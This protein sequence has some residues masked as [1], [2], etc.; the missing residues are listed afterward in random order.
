MSTCYSTATILNHWQIRI[1]NTLQSRDFF[2]RRRSDCTPEGSLKRVADVLYEDH[3]IHTSC[4][5]PACWHNPYS[6]ITLPVWRGSH[7][8]NT[9]NCIIKH[10]II[11][12][13]LWKLW[14]GGRYNCGDGTPCSLFSCH[15]RKMGFGG[16]MKYLSRFSRAE[17]K[18]SKQ[19]ITARLSCI[20][21]PWDWFSTMA[22]QTYTSRRNDADWCIGTF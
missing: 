7:K 13:R 10:V 15:P 6:Q 2:F 20:W 11:M 19:L 12:T 5:W 21:K 8:I 17:W 9:H 3:Y 22:N 14:T 4:Q 16:G 18:I 1:Y